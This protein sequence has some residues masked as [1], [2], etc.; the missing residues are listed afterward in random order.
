M[1]ILR[2]EHYTPQK[3]ASASSTLKDAGTPVWISGIS[4]LVRERWKQNITDLI[5]LALMEVKA[6]NR[7]C[8]MGHVF[9]TGSECI[10][11]F[12]FL[13]TIFQ[14]PQ[15]VPRFGQGAQNRFTTNPFQTSE[16]RF[17]KSK[18]WRTFLIVCNLWELRVFIMEK[19]TCLW[20]Q[21]KFK[22]NCS[23]WVEFSAPHCKFFTQ[24]AYIEL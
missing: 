14:P 10:W 11:K 1:T 22:R 4:A 18:L 3:L 7:N 17:F 2:W 9:G 15:Q 8:T 16:F 19:E 21:K 6:G 13:Q 12:P 24:V 5:L 23:N 20:G